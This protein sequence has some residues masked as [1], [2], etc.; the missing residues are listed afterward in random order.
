MRGKRALMVTSIM[1]IHCYMIEIKYIVDGSNYGCKLGSSTHKV[2]RFLAL[3]MR[4][5]V[6]QNI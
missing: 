4:E 1:P 2:F 5:M 3:E 6:K